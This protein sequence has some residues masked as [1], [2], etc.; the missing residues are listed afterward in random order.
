MAENG[1]AGHHH[2]SAGLSSGVH[3]MF[4]DAAVDFDMELEFFLIDLASYNAAFIE[5][6]GHK[7]LSAESWFYRHYKH[8]INGIKIWQ[9]RFDRSFGFNRYSD[10]ASELTQF[11]DSICRILFSFD[12]ECDQFCTGLDK[13]SGI[14]QRFFDHQMCVEE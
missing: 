7:A 11:G 10:G 6:F 1:G 8:Q 12:M 2:I 14:P 3:G 13:L 5:D 9:N 4:V